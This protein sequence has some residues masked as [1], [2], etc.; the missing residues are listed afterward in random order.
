MHMES[1]KYR[2]RL[3]KARQDG[4][5]TGEFDTQHLQEIFKT[6]GFLNGIDPDFTG[7]PEQQFRKGDRIV[8]HYTDDCH[9]ARKPDKWGTTD[10]CR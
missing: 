4:K 3:L 2:N 6:D 8:F 1:N 5:N 7:V 10:R 9:R